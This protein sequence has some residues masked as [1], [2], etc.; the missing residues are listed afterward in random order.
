MSTAP[1][2]TVGAW[3]LL[4]LGLVIAGLSLGTVAWTVTRNSSKPIAIPSRTTVKLAEGISTI[5]AD[6]ALP[7]HCTLD[8][9]K[10][11]YKIDASKP[12]VLVEVAQAGDYTLV[13]DAAEPLVITVGRG[14]NAAKIMAIAGGVPAAIGIVMILVVFVLRRRRSAA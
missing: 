4:G 7:F 6:R 1:K 2:R 10:R 11:K 14:T 3:Y 12:T 8:E 13:C 9:L 5:T